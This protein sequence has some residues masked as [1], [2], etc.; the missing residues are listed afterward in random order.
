MNTRDL[1]DRFQ[2]WQQRAGESMRNFGQT[3]DTYVREN[4]WTTL[5]IAAALGCVLG[6]LLA[7]G[8]D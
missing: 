8:R 3:T 1:T 4:T 7:G 5:A 2:D 6:Y